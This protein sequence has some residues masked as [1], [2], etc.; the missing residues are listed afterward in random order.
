MVWL[1]TTHIDKYGHT[2]QRKY[3]LFSNTHLHDFLGYVMVL[4]DYLWFI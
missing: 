1:A 4:A 2:E 3:L